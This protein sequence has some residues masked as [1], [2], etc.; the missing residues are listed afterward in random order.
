MFKFDDK[1]NLIVDNGV[2]V[3]QQYYNVN[4]IKIDNIYYKYI[5]RWYSSGRQIAEVLQPV[6]KYTPSEESYLE[7]NPIILEMMYHV[8]IKE[9][10]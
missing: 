2:Y 8:V 10:P 3:D 9:E 4:F 6:E 7:C 5:S 1:D